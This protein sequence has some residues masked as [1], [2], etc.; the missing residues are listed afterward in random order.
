M[1]PYIT[2]RTC[3]FRTDFKPGQ[4]HRSQGTTCLPTF[5]S[6]S[7]RSPCLPQ[8]AMPSCQIPHRPLLRAMPFRRQSRHKR[9]ELIV[10]RILQDCFAVS[11]C[12]YTFTLERK[13]SAMLSSPTRTRHRAP[14]VTSHGASHLRS[15]TRAHSHSRPSLMATLAITHKHRAVTTR[16]T[17]HKQATFTPQHSV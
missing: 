13:A 10:N 16:F 11:L 1:L 15:L 14:P 2:L 5:G 4:A 8:L 6:S 12:T 9:G 7:P 3:V 17:T